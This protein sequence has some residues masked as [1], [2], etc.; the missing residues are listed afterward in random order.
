MQL[1]ASSIN[2]AALNSGAGLRLPVLWDGAATATLASGLDGTAIRS[3][4][5][6]ASLEYLGVLTGSAERFALADLELIWV[7]DIEQ[8]VSR[9]GQGAA[10]VGL[11]GDLYYTKTVRAYG[12]ALVA[13]EA[14]GYVGVIFGEGEIP[15]LTLV[16]SLELTRAHLGYGQA[17][18][19][20]LSEFS[21]SAVRRTTMVADTVSLSGDLDPAHID[22]LGQRFIT[23]S[24][25]AE[26][27]TNVSDQGMKRQTQIGLLEFQVRSDG[28]AR[29]IRTSLAGDGVTTFSASLTPR[30]IRYAE[31]ASASVVSADGTGEIFVR[32]DMQAVLRVQAVGTGYVFRRTAIGEAVLVIDPV[33]NGIRAKASGGD[34]ELELD[35]ELDGVRARSIAGQS[36]IKLF[37]TSDAYLNPAAMD[38]EEQ[39]FFRP[40]TVR[41]FARPTTQREFMRTP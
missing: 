28:F 3:L 22:D 35:T 32:G 39:W 37:S 10:V 7:S 4:S 6:D 20:L 5:G 30:V 24:S 38:I 2:R 13:I 17:Y 14:N 9:N 19:A 27:E 34:I 12:N 31:G 21:A 8:S 41:D 25:A 26:I 23:G 16:P 40:D 36:I 11:A 15:L 1:N 18:T 33:L 29:A